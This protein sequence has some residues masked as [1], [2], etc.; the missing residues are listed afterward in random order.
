VLFLA[1]FCL[2]IPTSFGYG[3]GFSDAE[4]RKNGFYLDTL[5]DNDDRAFY[6]VYCESGASLKVTIEVDYPTYDLDINLFNS[7][8]SFR[9]SSYNYG[10]IDTVEGYPNIDGYYYIEVLR[11]SPSDGD[12]PFVLTIEGARDSRIPGFDIVALLIGVISVS[13]VIC[14]QVK[15]KQKTKT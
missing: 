4:I 10:D 12:I 15:K 7:Y 13:G 8:Q 1:S 3:S 14:F 11:Y 9:D 6:K 2:L 5:N